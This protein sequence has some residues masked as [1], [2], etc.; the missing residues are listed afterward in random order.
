MPYIEEVS[1]TSLGN[2]DMPL[3][4]PANELV[5]KAFI[6]MYACPSDLGLQQNEWSL[7]SWARVR[8]N[9]VVNAGNTT[10]GQHNVGNCPM[11]A[12]PNCRLF[13]GSTLHSPQAKPAREE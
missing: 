1:L 4:N 11:G 8:T 7:P 6:P 10:Y 5:R 2:P 13:G 12:F 3:S 9:Y